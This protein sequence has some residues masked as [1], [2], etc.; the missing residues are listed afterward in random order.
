M[1]R[2]EVHGNLEGIRDTVIDKLS[3]LYDYQVDETDFLPRELMEFLSAMSGYLRR[4]IAVYITR[5]GEIVDVS[6]GTDHD[7]E[8]RAVR[9]YASQRRR[10]AQ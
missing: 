1:K 6:V 7:V 2:E 10:H 9:A 4:E 5:D 8:L 3:S